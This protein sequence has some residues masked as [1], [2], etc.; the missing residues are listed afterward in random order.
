MLQN[1]LNFCIGVLLQLDKLFCYSMIWKDKQ[2]Q[3]QLQYN[4]AT[5]NRGDVVFV[6]STMKR[7]VITNWEDLKHVLIAS[8]LWHITNEI[9]ECLRS[10]VEGGKFRRIIMPRPKIVEEYSG[11]MYFVDK[12]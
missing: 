6:Y 1:K 8:S 12:G 11:K 4:G 7:V 2:L 3:I 9:G 5:F 10:L